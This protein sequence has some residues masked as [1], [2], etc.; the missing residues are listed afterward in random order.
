MKKI[1][2][3]RWLVASGKSTRAKQMVKDNPWKYK[4]ISKDDLRAMLDEWRWSK[5]NEKMVL[6]FRDEMIIESLVNWFNVIIDD[7]NFNPVHEQRV[8]EIAKIYNTKVE[9]KE[10]N[11]PVW[12]C[13]ERDSKRE[14]PVWKDVILKMREQYVY[15][16]LVQDKSFPKCIIVDIDWT[17]AKKWDRDIYDDSK[18]HLDTIIEPVKQ[19]VNQEK[20]LVF[21][22]SWRQDSYKEQTEKW[23]KD[24]WVVFCRTFF[25]EAWDTRCDAI[26]KREIYEKY[27]K[28]KFYIKFVIDDR[29]RVVRQ[30]RDLWLFVFD[31]NQSGVDF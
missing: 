24:N 31:V 17:L 6:K 10:F 15:K 23:L 4:R 22:V 30:W 5:I 20:D 18:L 9:V 19:I 3:T 29:T 16:P 25:R 26:V 13:I 28:D 14:N 2:M 21:I 12:E 11:T 27:F 1:I 7:T 8:R